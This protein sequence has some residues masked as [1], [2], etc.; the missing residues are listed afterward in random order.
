MKEVNGRRR[1]MKTSRRR[2]AARNQMTKLKDSF[3]AQP[4]R[5]FCSLVKENTKKNI[6]ACYLHALCAKHPFYAQSTI[7]DRTAYGTTKDEVCIKECV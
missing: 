2:A 3:D 7:L 4:L 1:H 5:H 6:K